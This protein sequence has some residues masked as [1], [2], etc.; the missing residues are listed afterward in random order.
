MLMTPMLRLSVDGGEWFD[1][2]TQTFIYSKPV[3]VEL[4]HSLLSLSKWESKWKKPFLSSMERQDITD[5]QLL[6]YFDC[7]V[8]NDVDEP[9]WVLM[10]SRQDTKRIIEYV[11]TEQTATT[12]HSYRPQRRSREIVTS[13]M[14]YYWMASLNIPYSCET[15]HLSRLLTLI[16]IASIKGRTG[17]KMPARDVR[18]MY[19]EINEKRKKQYNTRG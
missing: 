16:H 8:I 13:E 15:W 14:I 7:M 1:D 3:T 10:L 11:G 5:A 17:E 6:S 9:R 2:V 4:E 12:F 18:Q 19:A